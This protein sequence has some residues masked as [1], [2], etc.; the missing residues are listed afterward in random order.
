VAVIAVIILAGNLIGAALTL[1]WVRATRT[2][3]RDLGFVMPASWAKDLIGGVLAG[4]AF[5][6]AMKA[7]VMPLLGAPESVPAYHYLVENTAAL[8]G[9]LFTVIVGGGFG[10][11]LIWRGFLFERL[12]TLLGRGAR[13]TIAIVMITTILFSLAHYHDLGLPGAEQALITGL[14]FGVT[15]ARTRR[16]WP[17]MIA[18][19]SFDV[20]AVLII[21]WN[22]EHAIADRFFH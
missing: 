7:I 6:L 12:G 13:A 9:I 14:A 20:V 16:L 2:P 15:F 5:K 11:E 1:V 22:A 17:V 10:E 4:V 18:H 8:P 21:Y 19:A 3:W